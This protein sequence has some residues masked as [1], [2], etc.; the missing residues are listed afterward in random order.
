MKYNHRR[1]VHK[2]INIQAKIDIKRKENTNK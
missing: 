1:I 2:W